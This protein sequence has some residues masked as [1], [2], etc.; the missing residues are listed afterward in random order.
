M[1][2]IA[3]FS[4][5][6]PLTNEKLA[7]AGTSHVVLRIRWD[8]CLA[9]VFKER[10][11]LYMNRILCSH[12]CHAL[13][14]V[15]EAEVQRIPLHALTCKGHCF[16]LL[17]LFVWSKYVL[18]NLLQIQELDISR[19]HVWDLSGLRGLSNL[20]VSINRDKAFPCLPVRCYCQILSCLSFNISKVGGSRQ[21][22]SLTSSS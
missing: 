9:L 17:L 19:N 2:A 8:E 20:T 13:C 11:W 3:Q 22:S 4:N 14:T 12:E 5:F 21:N 1:H 7:W 16:F 6:K 10:T 15:W 18:I